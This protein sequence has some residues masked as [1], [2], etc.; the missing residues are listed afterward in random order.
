MRSPWEWTDGK[1]LTDTLLELGFLEGPTTFRKRAALADYLD[2]YLERRDK[3]RE[4]SR[5]GNMDFMRSTT[6]A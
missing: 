6:D 2:G 5:R 1:G 4:E 3:E